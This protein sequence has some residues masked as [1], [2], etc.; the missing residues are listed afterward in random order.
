MAEEITSKENWACEQA[1]DANR[2][3]SVCISNPNEV[4]LP[5]ATS[6]PANMIFL[7]DIVL[8]EMCYRGA[9]SPQLRIY[10]GKGGTGATMWN[11]E[12]GGIRTCSVTPWGALEAMGR[13]LESLIAERDNG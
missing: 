1:V 3:Q 5:I 7:A 4:G 12:F 10:F 11:C 6:I 9:T 13:Q 8:R 2:G